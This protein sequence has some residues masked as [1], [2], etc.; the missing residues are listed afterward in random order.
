[1]P[2][3][4]TIKR[5]ITE[6]K[7]LLQFGFLRAVGQSLTMVEPLVVAKFFA[8]ELFAN[9]ALAKMIVFFFLTMLIA[10]SMS[11]FIVFANQ[12]R[13]QTG[14]I[15]KAF[16]VQATLL[17]LG[18]CIFAA[19]IVPFNRHF[20]AFAGISRSDLVFVLLAFVGLALKTFVCNLLMA[21]NE[22]IKNA[23]A[24]L[25]FG[26]L[27]LAFIICLAVLHSV[28]LRS[29]FAA[30]F[31]ASVVLGGLFIRT[32]DFKLLRPFELDRGYVRR[33]L[34]F[35]G[36][37]M[38]G[39]AAIFL[40]DW[41][42]NFPLRYYD[43]PMGKIG[44]YNFAY[45]IFKG[46]VV[47]I[48][49]MDS[50]FSPFVSMNIG[51]KE[52]MRTYVYSK[53]PKAFLLGLAAICVVFVCAP[54]AL[55]LIYKKVYGE[56]VAI[57]MVLLAGSV[58][59]LYSTFYIPLLD[60]L[61]RYKFAQMVNISQGIAK[62]GLGLLLVPRMGIYGVAVAT[63]VVYLGRAAAYEIYFRKRIAGLFKE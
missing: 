18:L 10:S 11:P 37:V 62:I 4:N 32:I 56:S 33:M 31:A 1:M 21:V 46:V 57:L 3:L 6:G 60:A 23:L 58:L 45:A 5:E 29:V 50:Y 24:E 55:G 54:Y 7:T 17:V 51:N 39:A 42:D 26:V 22:R 28:N 9:Y 63:I 8:P 2:I 36:W 16:S 20:A 30:Q 43:V 59:C 19:L 41:G 27:S 25:V 61:K 15:N 53:R 34:S 12:E 38:V 44:V 13:P 52:S 47:L 40:V 48:S 49:I 14:K 35:T